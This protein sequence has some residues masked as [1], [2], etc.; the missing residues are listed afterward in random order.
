VDTMA[1]LDLPASNDGYCERI[2]G[3]GA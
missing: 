1:R 2:H 3:R